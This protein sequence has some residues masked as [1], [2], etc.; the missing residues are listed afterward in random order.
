MRAKLLR[1]TFNRRFVSFDKAI[2]ILH[3]RL[4]QRQTRIITDWNWSQSYGLIEVVS[5]LEIRQWNATV[6]WCDERFGYC[7]SDGF[8]TKS[9]YIGEWSDIRLE[10]VTCK[11]CS[12]NMGYTKSVIGCWHAEPDDKTKCT[13]VDWK[14]IFWLFI[15]RRRWSTCYWRWLLFVPCQLWLQISNFLHTISWVNDWS[16]SRDPF[17]WSALRLFQNLWTT[18]CKIV[19]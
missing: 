16:A 8:F 1:L 7:L 3:R 2:R 9:T 14:K 18:Y 19:K 4:N 13:A 10:S 11:M 5:D 6:D 15:D 17:D 12:L